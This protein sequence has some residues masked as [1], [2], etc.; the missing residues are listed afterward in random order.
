MLLECKIVDNCYSYFSKVEEVCLRA[1][2]N[3]F[4]VVFP[5]HIDLRKGSNKG[6]PFI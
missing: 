2:H 5:I 6:S 4:Y 3:N 1:V